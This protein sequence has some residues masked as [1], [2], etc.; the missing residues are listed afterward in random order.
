MGIITLLLQSIGSLQASVAVSFVTSVCRLLTLVAE[1]AG[2]ETPFL[3]VASSK[4]IRSKV[5][6]I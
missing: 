1:M 2:C 3:E 6:L 4:P 5:L